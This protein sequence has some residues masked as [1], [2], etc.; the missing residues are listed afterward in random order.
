MHVQK[1]SRW[2]SQWGDAMNARTVGPMCMCVAIVNS[3]MPRL[4][5]SAASQWQNAWST[6]SVLTFALNLKLAPTISLL[7]PHLHAMTYSPKPT[8]YSNNLQ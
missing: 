5:T 2:H 7:K 8:S 3:T 4:I 6:K 1:V